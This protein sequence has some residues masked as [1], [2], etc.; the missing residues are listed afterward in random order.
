[1]TDGESLSHALY[2]EEHDISADRW[3]FEY[4]FCTNNYDFF[5]NKSL[6]FNLVYCL[7]KSMSLKNGPRSAH[8]DCHAINIHVFVLVQE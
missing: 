4:Y 3:K 7:L 8:D 6:V 5:T 1:M 2:V